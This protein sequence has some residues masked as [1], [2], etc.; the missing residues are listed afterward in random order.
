MTHRVSVLLLLLSLTTAFAYAQEP[1][2]RAGS[3]VATAS[4]AQTPPTVDGSVLDDEAWRTAKVITGFWQTT[5]RRGTAGVGEHRG[6]GSLHRRSLYIGVVNYDRSPDHII[7]A[8]GRRDASLTDTDSFLVILDTFRD[9]QNGFVFGTSPAGIEYDGQVIGEG[10]RRGGRRW[11][12]RRRWWGRRWWRG[13]RRRWWGRRRSGWRIGRRI[14]H[15][16]G[17]VLAGRIANVRG[18]LECGV[19]DSVPHAALSRSRCAGMGHQLSAQHPPSQRNRPTG[20]RCRGSTTC[21][22]CRSQAR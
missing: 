2:P 15:Q 11:W 7:S 8:E 12:W 10:Q 5:P 6:A 19:R 21:I 14:Q 18:R 20:R 13:W 9:R 22:A 3:V 17:R 1:P 4:P 16:L